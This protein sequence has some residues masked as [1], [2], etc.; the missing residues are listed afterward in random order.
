MTTP[1]LPDVTL[2]YG[3]RDIK[4]YPYTADTPSATGTDLPNARTLQF[5]ETEQFA[6]LRGDDA[7]KATHGQGPNVDWTLESG[8]VPLEAIKAMFGG[9]I[10][11]TGTSPA[12]VKTYSATGT[13]QRP[14]FKLAAQ[15]ISDSGGDF[16][17]V[18]Y[19]CKCTGDLSGTMQD[20]GFWLTG[21]KGVGLS[22][23]DDN[24]Y[25]FVQNEEATPLD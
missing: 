22:D 7:L 3:C 6:E 20:S 8:G 18:I 14:Y 24:L 2:P 10:T 16:Q 9:T 21:A 15:A 1:T 23:A 13:K 25:D 19:K 12:Q 17:V 5:A 11:S 4:I